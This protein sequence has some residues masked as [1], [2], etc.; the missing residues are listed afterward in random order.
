MLYKDDQYWNILPTGTVSAYPENT[1]LLRKG[2]ITEQL[3]SCLTVLDSTKLLNLY[4]IEHK[5]SSWILTSQTGDQA[6]S[7]TSPYKSF[8]KT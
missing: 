7:D 5:Q 1:H 3:I 2:S 6:Y 4:L 8:Y